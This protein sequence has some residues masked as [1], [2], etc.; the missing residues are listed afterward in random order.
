M[1]SGDDLRTMLAELFQSHLKHGF[2]IRQ[3]QETA[4]S[5]DV[6]KAK[7]WAAMASDPR[8]LD[9]ADGSRANT[10]TQDEAEVAVNLPNVVVDSDY[11]PGR[12]T[13]ATSTTK[14]DSSEEPLSASNPWNIHSFTKQVSDQSAVSRASR[15]KLPAG[16]ES[17]LKTF[18]RS[19]VFD[20]I[21][22]GILISNAL[23][24]GIQVEAMFYSSQPPLVLEII[25][26]LFCL[27][28]LM[29]LV[30]RMTGLGVR[31]Y[32]CGSEELYWN[33]FDFIIVGL[34]SI[35][36]LM[37]L[38]LRG[39][40]SPLGNVAILRVIRVIRITRV[41]RV[42]RVMKFFRDLRILLAAVTST[43]KT[44]IFAFVLIFMAMYMCGIA[45]GQMTAEHLQLQEASDV[46]LTVDQKKTQ[47]DLKFFFGSIPR[48]MLALFMTIAG[49]I[50]WKD[51]AI[52]LL[53]ISQVAFF[54][55]ICFVLL[56]IL[57]V[58]N[59]LTGIF[60]QCAIETAQSDKESVIMFQMQEK[61]RF[62]ETLTNL[63]SEWDESGDGK[64][65]LGEF[66]SHLQDESMQA[67][68]R[69]LEI[70]VRDALTLFELLDTEGKGEVDLDEFITGCI[71]LRGG[72]KAVHMEKSHAMFKVV[73]DRLESFHENLET[74]GKN[75]DTLMTAAG[76]MKDERAIRRSAP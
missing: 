44:A 27:L 75:V 23:F 36:A 68:L 39:Q 24:I 16:V 49:G 50:D 63:F 8:V 60:C 45:I 17:K 14:E 25:D 32:L 66:Q 30:L 73:S 59:V 42:I 69:S 6:R 18:V 35:D 56:M 37:S 34:S 2:L 62:I 61:H 38:I 11:A 31:G 22:A 53:E 28:F 76:M 72:A 54:I 52:P 57:C 74:I 55:Y 21:S 19:P 58:M 5:A 26:Y 13:E 43:L 67:L 9:V 40:E 48:A 46:K 70:E 65:S 20:K 71:T 4:V 64:C 47:D 29:E 7:H 33:W 15:K 3:L 10:K 41:L 1:S 51:A 12:G